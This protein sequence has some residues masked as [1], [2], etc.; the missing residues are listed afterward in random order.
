MSTAFH[1]SDWAHALTLSDAPDSVDQLSRAIGNA[2]VDLNPHQV[3][4]APQDR[5]RLSPS[6]LA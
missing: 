3:D 5:C 4:A 1:A 6:Q 2:R